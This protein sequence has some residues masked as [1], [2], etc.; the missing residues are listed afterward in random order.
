M[1][2]DADTDAPL[3]YSVSGRRWRDAHGNTYHTARVWVTGLPGTARDLPITYGYG[4]H[5]LTTATKWLHSQGVAVDYRD[6]RDEG[7]VDVKRKR[8][9]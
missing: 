3:H 1:H 8:D 2:T 9:L 7:A 5:Y 4:C 6:L